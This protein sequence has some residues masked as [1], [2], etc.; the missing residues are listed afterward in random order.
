MLRW[1]LGALALLLTLT[2]GAA[3]FLP[4]VLDTAWLKTR[5]GGEIERRTGRKAAIGS[6]SFGWR[7]GL[8]FRDVTLRQK[9]E[10]PADAGPLLSLDRLTIEV[11]FED[12]VHRRL[13]FE[14]IAL[15]SPTIVVIRDEAGKLNFSDLLKASRERT[16]GAPPDLHSFRIE[17]G[18]VLFVDRKLGVTLDVGDIEAEGRIET[19]NMSIDAR[20]GLNGGTGALAASASF[21]KREPSFSV[22]RLEMEAVE[23]TADLTHL[24]YVVPLIG[25]SPEKASGTLS[26]ALRD[27]SGSG[28]EAPTLRRTL[29]G[30]GT[31]AIGGGLVVS[32]ASKALLSAIHDIRSGRAPSA[33]ALERS[34]EQDRTAPV[35]ETAGL[36]IDRLS[37][38]FE[39]GGGKIA[40][41]DMSLRTDMLELMFDGWIRL[42]GRSMR[43]SISSDELS[44]LVRERVA[45][46]HGPMEAARLAGDVKL[47]LTG[48]LE[49]PRIALDLSSALGRAFERSTSEIGERLEEEVRR[50]AGELLGPRRPEG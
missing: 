46:L 10:D 11:S 49:E 34:H 35:T 36:R 22:K 7:R 44:S 21:A 33:K 40:S 25:L 2:A 43:Y 24:G 12:L 1:F 3:F 31:I 19:G 16:R 5:I 42:D 18:R 30:H 48:S 27:L 28:A 45:A 9:P 20:F 50:R 23:V 17:R 37:A 32:E 39:V 6:V 26:L 29:S 47:A 38:T 4:L 14:R 13:R 8:S 15:V 41:R